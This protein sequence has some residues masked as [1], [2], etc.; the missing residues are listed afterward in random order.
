[1]KHTLI[2]FLIVILALTGC[3]GTAGKPAA[4]ATKKTEG[5]ATSQDN[6]IWASGKLLPAVLGRPE[7][8]CQRHAAHPERGRRRCCRG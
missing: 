3:S 8:G 2:I 6:V 4:D 1:M 5:A 7:S